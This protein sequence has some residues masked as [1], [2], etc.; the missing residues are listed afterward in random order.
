MRGGKK[1]KHTKHVLNSGFRQ[2]YLYAG[3]LMEDKERPEIQISLKDEEYKILVH[4][5]YI[6][7]GWKIYLYNLFNEE[8]DIL[9]EFNRVDIRVGEPNYNY[10]FRIKNKKR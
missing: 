5:K 7:D 10:Y 8:Y 1:Q 9:L 4:E 6:K 2:K 3:L